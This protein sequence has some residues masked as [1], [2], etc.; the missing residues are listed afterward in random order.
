MPDG[1]PVPGPLPA[2]QRSE[3]RSRAGGFGYQPGYKKLT[4][5]VDDATIPYKPSAEAPVVGTSTLALAATWWPPVEVVP[6]VTV[7]PPRYSVTA[8]RFWI[9]MP[10][11]SGAELGVAIN[12]AVVPTDTTPFLYEKWRC[13][14]QLGVLGPAE[15]RRLVAWCLSCRVVTVEP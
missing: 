13:P 6:A 1:P 10:S 8:P 7:E 4:F 14:P 12:V 11:T 15:L 3:G 2:R 5:A 9:R